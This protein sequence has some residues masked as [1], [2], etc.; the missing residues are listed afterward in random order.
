[1][2]VGRL[3]LLLLLLLLLASLNLRLSLSSSSLSISLR[4]CEALSRFGG[5]GRFGRT[6]PVWAGIE[7]E[8]GPAERCGAGGGCLPCLGAGGFTGRDACTGG[9]DDGF[10]F[11]GGRT[12][13]EGGG[14]RVEGVLLSRG[15]DEEEEAG[16]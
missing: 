13:E 3:L 9:A 8:E 10:G 1:M 2:D 6:G 12:E 15:T 7:E 11:T 16:G 5:G 4:G 14:R